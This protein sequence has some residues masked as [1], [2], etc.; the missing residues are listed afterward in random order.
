MET[1]AVKIAKA[2][3]GDAP[4]M[5]KLINFFADRG[6]MLPRPLSEIYENIRDYFVA[7]EG[8]V[9]VACVALHVAWGDLAEIKSLAVE[10]SR[11]SQ[12]L[13]FELVRACLEEARALEI[14]TLFCLT[15]KPAFFEKL[16]FRQVDVMSLPRKVWGECYRCSKFPNC[17]ETALVLS[18]APKSL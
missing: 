11:Q 17:D 5:H 16:G 7:R 12:G 9:V 2:R 8:D 14:P 15:Y 10:E 6:E 1:S 13:G 4:V 18:L 3:I